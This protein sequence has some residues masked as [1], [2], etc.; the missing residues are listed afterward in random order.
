MAT[1]LSGVQIPVS[2][3]V[4]KALQQL[5]AMEGK[6]TKE[7]AQAKKVNKDAQNAIANTNVAKKMGVGGGGG[8]GG[9]PTSQNAASKLAGFAA[10]RTPIGQ[11]AGG[12]ARAVGGLL[13]GA[14]LGAAKFA[15]AA[16]LGYGAVS[17][18]AQKL[19][20][21]AY[22]MERITGLED[23]LRGFQA[24][25]EGLRRGFSTFESGITT[26]PKSVG[27]TKD[28]VELSFR[29]GGGMPNVGSLFRQIHM[30]NVYESELDKKFKQFANKE[31]FA[32]AGDAFLKHA[33]RSGDIMLKAF[34]MKGA[35]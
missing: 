22:A 5:D 17:L 29:L 19:P 33:Q 18:A 1:R 27:E 28:V 31:V 14:A 15:G 24:G 9:T 2:L 25:L 34:G 23:K 12:A 35:N 13:P 11:I 3:D 21:I 4:S 16:A 30:A 7:E 10:G 6:L 8:G 26:L 32:G 20:E